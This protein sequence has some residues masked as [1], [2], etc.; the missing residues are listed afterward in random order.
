V[1]DVESH[2]TILILLEIVVGADLVTDDLGLSSKGSSMSPRPP[3][4]LKLSVPAPVGMG[5]LKMI[6][7][8]GRV[9]IFHW[10]FPLP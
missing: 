3:I 6:G 4:W 10:F 9:I 1:L 2:R 7:M 5:W 8:T